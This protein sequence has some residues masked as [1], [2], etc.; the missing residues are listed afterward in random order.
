MRGSAEF[1]GSPAPLDGSPL[2]AMLTLGHSGHWLVN[3]LYLAPVVGFIGWLGVVTWRERLEVRA[4]ERQRT[5]K[6]K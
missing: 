5:P 6:E 1:V 3:L 4:S 2:T